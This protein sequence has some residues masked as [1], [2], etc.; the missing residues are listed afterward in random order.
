MDPT[1][2]KPSSS[3]DAPS[4]CV[5]ILNYN[6]RKLLGRFL[7][8]IAKTD[9]KPLELVVVDNASS[10]DSCGWLR[11]RWPQVTL[12][13]SAKNLAWA[14]GNNIGI[15]YAL[16]KRHRYIVLANNDIQ[17]H[18][19]WVRQ[20]VAHAQA[21]PQ[22]RIIGF[23]LF[24]QE[25]S[26][27]AYEQA[28]QRLAPIAV[29]PVDDVTGCAMFC[30]AEVFRDLGL[31]DE[32]YWIYAE[33]TDFE[34]RAKLA[35]MQ[36][37]EINVPIWHLAEGTMSRVIYKRSYL[38]MRNAIRMTFKMDG[39]GAGLLVVKTVLNRACNPFLRL[40]SVS[41]DYTLM[42]YRPGKWPVNTALALAA[43]GWNLIALPCTLRAG[44]R[45][46]ALI[47]HYRERLAT[48]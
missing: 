11:A 16:S 1:N 41:S 8:L 25:V 7:P 4:V 42:R 40:E 36:M 38:Q 39:V 6:G 48:H 32:T 31:F 34:K 22:D 19:S 30:D 28:C 17:P 2:N 46:K 10:D 14:G 29:R 47:A 23:H 27:A 45:D 35:G 3:A 24:N 20:A 43:I 15:R 33:E 18:P 9:Y 5:V 13:R 21:T 12:L 44:W 26:R 37:A